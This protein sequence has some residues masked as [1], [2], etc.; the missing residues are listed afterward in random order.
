[1]LQTQVDHSGVKGRQRKSCIS[2]IT[3][4]VRSSG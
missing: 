2:H 4:K 1:V 3:A